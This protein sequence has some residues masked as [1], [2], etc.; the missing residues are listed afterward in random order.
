VKSPHLE[1]TV[2]LPAVLVVVGFLL[3]SLLSATLAA[4]FIR[5]DAAPAQLVSEQLEH[6]ILT[7]FDEI[8]KRV[9]DLERRLP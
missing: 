5:R 6:E 4:L 9:E 2:A 8:S 3:L 7:R 1:R